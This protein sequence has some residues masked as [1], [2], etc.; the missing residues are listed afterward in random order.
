MKG[1]R[2]AEG[3]GEGTMK[4]RKHQIKS[5][6]FPPFHYFPL[7]PS[8][9]PI[10]FQSIPLSRPLPLLLS[11]PNFALS[12]YPIPAQQCRLQPHDQRLNEANECSR[13][14]N[15]CGLKSLQ[16]RRER[17]K[18]RRFNDKESLIAAY[19][20]TS[21][22]ESDYTPISFC[23]PQ[24]FNPSQLCLLPCTSL[25]CSFRLI[26]CANLLRSFRH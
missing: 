1:E 15:T 18:K 19:D 22:R 17:C 4:V 8:L 13:G 24:I 3:L 23:V 6:N 25:E 2:W 21:W 26:P 20:K 7:S 5:L 11:S 14:A 10:Q 12:R 16:K 9:P